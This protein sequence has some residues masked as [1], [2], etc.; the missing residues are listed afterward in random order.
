M[1]DRFF[2]CTDCRVPFKADKEGPFLGTCAFCERPVVFQEKGA[3][4]LWEAQ[5]AEA[6]PDP[7]ESGGYKFPSQ[8]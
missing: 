1:T 4:E 3:R 2:M 7:D 5:E 8:A 6:E